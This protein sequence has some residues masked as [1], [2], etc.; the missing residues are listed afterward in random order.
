MNDVGFNS[1]EAVYSGQAA[2]LAGHEEFSNYFSVFRAH[3]ILFQF[4]VSIVYQSFGVLDVSARFISAIFG[5]ATVA[6]TYYVGKTLYNRHVGMLS[7]LILALLPYHIII[8]RQ[9]LVDVPFSFFFTLTLLFVAKFLTQDTRNNVASGALSSFKIDRFGH[10][11]EIWLYAIGAC[12]GLSFL[13]KEVGVLTLIVAIGY[14]QIRHK[15]GARNL[16]LI[17]VSFIVAISPFVI[18]I[19]MEGEAAN[20]AFLYSQWQLNRPPNHSYSFYPEVLVGSLGYVLMGL[21]ILTA[22]Y[23]LVKRS[24]KCSGALLL[25]WISI[26]FLFFQIWPTKGF[27]YMVPLIPALVILGTSFLFSDWMKKIR[28]SQIVT[29]LLM[30]LIFLSTNYVIMHLVG[31][32]S[33]KFLA[34]SGGIPLGRETAQWIKENTPEGSVFMTIGPTMANLIKFY[35]N[36]DALPLSINPNP[37]KH[38]PSYTPIINP[39]L[40]IRNGQ[41]HYIVY[42]MYSAARTEH[43]ANKLLYY[44][45]KFNAQLIHAEHSSYRNASGP[46]KPV[47][48]IYVVNGVK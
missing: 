47:T 9:A 38:N 4:I 40:M 42:D 6:V 17:L 34:G 32:P 7:A 15:L 21:V 31:A 2:T 26:P 39:D 37:G 22:G 24:A 36:R 30:P 10:G 48:E 11:R 16:A 33:N 45:D 46:A 3:P 41:I 27:Y 19:F 35:A 5:I 1:D 23:V 8:S 25:F 14:L 29:I 13:S 28:Y 18:S 20:N 43:F 12:A 44:A